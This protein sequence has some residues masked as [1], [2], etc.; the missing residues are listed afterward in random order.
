MKT[1]ILLF[2]EIMCV[3]LLVIASLQGGIEVIGLKIYK[4]AYDKIALT[5]MS[6][7]ILSCLVATILLI[8]PIKF[9]QTIESTI[10]FTANT[11]AWISVS[12]FENAVGLTFNGSSRHWFSWSIAIWL[13]SLLFFYIYQRKTSD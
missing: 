4:I 11:V 5:F 1:K 7:C 12:V 9:W 13:L 8:K 6:V 3:V 10:F 2:V